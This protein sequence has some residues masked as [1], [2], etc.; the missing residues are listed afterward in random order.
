MKI[1]KRICQ[2]S[3]PVVALGKRFF[4][5][6]IQMTRDDAYRLVVSLTSQLTGHRNENTYKGAGDW[7]NRLSWGPLQSCALSQDWVIV[8]SWLQL[9]VHGATCR[10]TFAWPL[11]LTVLLT[12]WN[13]SYLILHSPHSAILIHFTQFVQF[14]LGTLVLL[15]ACVTLILTFEIGI[16]TDRLT[17][18][19]LDLLSAVI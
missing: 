19:Q 10:L 8:H 9:L 1:A 13:L 5:R 12:N 16:Q 3:R 15:C 17:N 4:Y 14:L 11:L 18:R 7:E 6:Q 2:T